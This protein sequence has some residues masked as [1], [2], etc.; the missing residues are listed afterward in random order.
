VARFRDAEG[1]PRLELH[2]A[3]AAPRNIRDGD[4]VRVFND[5]GSFTLR[6]LVNDKPRARRGG[7]A[8]AV[9]AQVHARPAQRQRRH[10]AAHRGHGRRGP[11]SHDCLVEV[12]RA[13]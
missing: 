12:E 9:V 7:G 10:L 2:A 3:D 6:A 1:E 11:R 13:F 4:S 8:V 5:R